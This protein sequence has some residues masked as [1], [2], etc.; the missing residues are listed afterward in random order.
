MTS[1]K[2]F[3]IQF[4]KLDK[5]M[6]YSEAYL[7]LGNPAMKILT[8]ILFHQRW[9]NV[10]RDKSKPRWIC[11]NTDD[12]KLLYTIF[13]SKPFNM[14][15]K[16]ITR[17]IDELL[18]KGFIKVMEQGGKNKGHASCFK[19]VE[20]YLAWSKGDAPISKRRPYRKRGYCA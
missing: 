20:N 8:Y 6:A 12:L 18:A 11:T 9:E 17:G 7:S 10:S 5:S 1:Q 16:S 15:G 19:I 2:K 3:K 4:A 13:Y 14:Q